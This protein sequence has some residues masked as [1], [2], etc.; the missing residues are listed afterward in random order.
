MVS[1][2]NRLASQL[3]SSNEHLLVAVFGEQDPATLHAPAKEEADEKGDN[4]GDGSEEDSMHFIDR[5]INS[6]QQI[7]KQG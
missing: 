5:L 2:G 1:P 7:T 3:S 4:K 6:K